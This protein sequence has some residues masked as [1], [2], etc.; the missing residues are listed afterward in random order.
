MVLDTL[1]LMHSNEVSQVFQCGGGDHWKPREP[2]FKT[3]F[4]DVVRRE[5]VVALH[6]RNVFVISLDW[7]WK[8]R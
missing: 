5:N 3:Y 2:H 1:I 4:S 6:R 8:E 7:V